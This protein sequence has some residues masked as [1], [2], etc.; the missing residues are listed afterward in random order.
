MLIFFKVDFN[1]N[2][3]FNEWVNIL[4]NRSNFNFN[5]TVNELDKV[6]TL[7]TCFNDYGIRMVVQAK[8]VKI[9]K[10]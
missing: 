1:S 5:T 3:E 2:Y 9:Q 8:L 10:K 6:L 4:K 7:S